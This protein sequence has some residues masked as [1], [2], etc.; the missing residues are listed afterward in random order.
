MIHQVA[1]S[2]SGSAF[3]EITL[4]FVQYKIVREVC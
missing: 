1:A 2:I 4:V 3:Y